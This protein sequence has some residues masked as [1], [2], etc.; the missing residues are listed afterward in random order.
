M[1]HPEK[2]QSSSESDSIIEPSGSKETSN[3]SISK[4]NKVEEELGTP[5]DHVEQHQTVERWTN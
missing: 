2:Y 5:S 3:T 1:P 4:E